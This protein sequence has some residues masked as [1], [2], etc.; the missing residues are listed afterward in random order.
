MLI[1]FLWH[2]VVHAICFYFNDGCNGCCYQFHVPSFL[3]RGTMTQRASILGMTGPCVSAGPKAPA[4]RLNLIPSYHSPNWI[5]C[6][7][8]KKT[9]DLHFWHTLKRKQKWSKRRGSREKEG[10]TKNSPQL[11]HLKYLKTFAVYL[12][13]TVVTETLVIFKGTEKHH[14]ILVPYMQN[15]KQGH[16]AISD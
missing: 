1:L 9:C 7:Q 4:C 2:S 8:E 3:S 12:T 5:D 13:V 11:P 16:K 10:T 15:L 6:S 14:L